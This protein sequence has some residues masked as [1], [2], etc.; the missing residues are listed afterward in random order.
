MR[1]LKDS[2]GTN[3][4]KKSGYRTSEQRLSTE[5]TAGRN[6]QHNDCHDD[7]V[8]AVELGDRHVVV[9][10]PIPDA[11]PDEHQATV[12]APDRGHGHGTQDTLS[13]AIDITFSSF[14]HWVSPSLLALLTLPQRRLDW[15]AYDLEGTT[16]L[17]K[18]EC[19]KELCTA[20][21]CCYC[22]SR[23]L[24]KMAH[25]LYCGGY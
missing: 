20:C 2:R 11:P 3:A 19:I 24:H 4:L 7:D 22:L 14:F 9:G 21:I 23:V 8:G 25:F 10:A 6:T 1:G 18:T 16:S 17:N 12:D 5:D 15:R 13:S